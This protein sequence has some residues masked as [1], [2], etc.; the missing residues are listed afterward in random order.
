[1]FSFYLG[2]LSRPSGYVINVEAKLVQLQRLYNRAIAV[3]IFTKYDLRSTVSKIGCEEIVVEVKKLSVE[4][5][6]KIEGFRHYPD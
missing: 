4:D 6:L 5:F 2:L 1:M 3:F